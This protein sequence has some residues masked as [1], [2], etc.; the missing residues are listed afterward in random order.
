MNVPNHL[1]LCVVNGGVPR[2]YTT[3]NLRW[4]AATHRNLAQPRHILPANP[5]RTAW[6][7]RWATFIEG[8]LET[9]YASH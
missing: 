5:E 7:I 8:L 4:L 6:H 1:Q 2:D 3:E 9:Y